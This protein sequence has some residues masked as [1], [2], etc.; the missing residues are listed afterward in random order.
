MTRLNLVLTV[1]ASFLSFAIAPAQS[2]DVASFDDTARFLAGMPP[3]EV[4]PLVALTKGRGW[5]QHAK[6]MDK[7]FAFV[8]KSPLSQI[9][10]WSTA[11]LKSPQPAMFY[12]FSG[13][14]FLFADAFFP[15]AT[16][17][18]LAGLE[19]S[20]DIPDLMKMQRR[21][22]VSG[23]GHLQNSMRTLLALSFFITKE[24]REN[25]G[26]S[27]LRGTIPILYV[28]LA[29][30][31]KHIRDTSLVYID[32]R[33]ELHPED[34]K[35]RSGARGVK[36]V[37][38]GADS[39][40]RTLYY[41]TTNLANDG[42]RSGG[43]LKFC[44]K[45]GPADSFHKSASYLMHE[46]EFSRIREFIVSKSVT[47]VQDDSG[48]PIRFFDEKIWQLHPFGRYLDPLSIFPQGRQPKI[49]E[50]FHKDRAGKLDFGIGYRWRP[51]ESNL[52]LAVKRAS[53]ET[54]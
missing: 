11:N 18:V 24:M 8:E 16:T 54:R 20:G 41:F 28:F 25:L 3:S 6:A 13:P 37:F 29:R 33:G 2:T 21:G 26:E 36:I 34:K 12:M 47:V 45:L 7:A 51:G 52:L 49:R 31:G 43:F 22:G 23:L 42:V 30:S 44:D 15:H 39:R 9:R 17:Y 5:Q 1:A 46:N 10:N 32:D 35:A 38:T 40:E 48:I 50:L 4:S 27:A 14:D 19:P 53:A